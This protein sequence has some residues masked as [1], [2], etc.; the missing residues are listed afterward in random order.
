M[1]FRVVVMQYYALVRKGV[2]VGRDDLVGAVETHVV[3]TLR[4]KSKCYQKTSLTSYCAEAYTFGEYTFE[5]LCI[6]SLIS[7]KQF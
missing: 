1:N 6:K 3:P 4:K 2:D 7:E 5:L